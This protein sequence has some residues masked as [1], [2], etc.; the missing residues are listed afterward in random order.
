MREEV[1]FNQSD[2]Y[3][4]QM[5]IYACIDFS[6]FLKDLMNFV[7]RP[8]LFRL[9]DISTLPMRKILKIIFEN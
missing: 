3:K 7:T 1:T 5:F 4:E 2:S 8:E 9:A 6:F